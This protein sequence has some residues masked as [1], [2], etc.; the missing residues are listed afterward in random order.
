[1][2][3]YIIRHG[4]SHLNLPDYTDGNVDEP[5]TALGHQQAEALAQWLPK[6]LPEVDVIY[7]STLRRAEETAQ[8]LA[9]TYGLT[10]RFDHRLREIGCNQTNKMPLSNSQLPQYADYWSSE[11]P[12]SSITP[13]IQYG[14]S[15]MDFRSR[16][17]SLLEEWVVLHLQQT[18]VAVCHSRV[19][20]IMFDHVFNIGPWRRCEISVDH[21]AISH[22]E[23]VCLPNRETWQ[24]HF[25]NQTQHL[26]LLEPN[27]GS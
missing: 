13:S 22:F 11:R 5:L 3:L 14:E 20:E 21:T 7:S 16:V 18:V 10:E 25:H 9:Y 8:V 4:E 2:H 23:Y 15:L 1:M 24:L 26:T 6:N 19:I 17:G 27:T 12:F